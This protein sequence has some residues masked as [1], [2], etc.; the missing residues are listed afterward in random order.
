MKNITQTMSIIK[1]DHKRNM[2]DDY[3]IQALCVSKAC[4]KRVVPARST[5]LNPLRPYMHPHNKVRDHLKFLSNSKSYVPEKHNIAEGHH[6]RNDKVQYGNFGAQNH[7]QPQKVQTI[8]VVV[9]NSKRHV[10]SLWYYNHS[11]Y[12]YRKQTGRP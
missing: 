11:A 1:E 6:R 8:L 12:C 9:P 2:C 3:G 5:E 4:A 10:Q 7:P